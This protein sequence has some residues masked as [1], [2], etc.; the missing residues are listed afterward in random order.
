MTAKDECEGYLSKFWG[1]RAEEKVRTLLHSWPE[2][3]L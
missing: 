2:P 1:A 3:G